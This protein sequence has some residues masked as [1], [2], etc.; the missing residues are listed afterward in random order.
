MAR[1]IALFNEGNFR[2]ALEEFKTGAMLDPVHELSHLYMAACNLAVGEIGAARDAAKRAIEINPKLQGASFLLGFLEVLEEERLKASEHLSKC[3]EL[4]P[5]FVLPLQWAASLLIEERR[6][7]KAKPVVERLLDTKPDSAPANHMS[8]VLALEEGDLSTATSRLERAVELLDDFTAAHRKLAEAYRRQGNKEK[9]AKHYERVIELDKTDADSTFQLGLLLSDLREIDAAIKMF[10]RVLGMKPSL[11]EAHYQI[12]LLLYV[13]KGAIDEAVVELKKALKLDPTDPSTRLILGELLYVKKGMKG[14]WIMVF[15]SW[16]DPRLIAAAFLIPLL[17]LLAFAATIFFGKRLPGK[18]SSLAIGAAAVSSCLSFVLLFYVLSGGRIEVSYPWFQAGK[19]VV[20]IGVTVDP[21]CALMLIVVSIVGLLVE[22][23][24]V[25]YMHGDP[26]FSRYFAYISLFIFSM[27]GLVL[28][29]SFFLLYIFWELVGICS[30]LLIGFWFERK[31]AAD[32]GKKAFITNRVGDFGFLVGVLLLASAAGTF[33]FSQIFSMA[34]HGQFAVGFLTLASVC[35]FA[36]AVGKSAQFPLHVWLPD[37]MEGPTPISALIHAATMVAA[38]V[39]MV[40]RCFPLFSASAQAS[41]VVA[42]IGG[43]TAIFAATIACTQFDIKRVLAYSTLS[44]LGYM[45]LGLG[46]GGYVAGMFH[47]MT[48]AFFKALLFLC[49]GSV[50]HAT[51]KQDI[52]EMGGLG[53]HMKVTSTTFL[54]A[55]LAIAGIPPFSGFWSKDEILVAV[56]RSGHTWLYLIAIAGA[57][58]T[59]FYMFRLYFVV[60]LGEEKCK[61]HES[62]SVMAVPLAILGVLSVCA[63]WVGMPW[64]RHGI[65]SFL[66]GGEGVEHHG[67][68]YAVMGASLLVAGAGI[69]ISYGTYVKG[70]IARDAFSR[71]FAPIYRLLYNKY[72]VDE[73]YQAYIVGPLVLLTKSLFTFDLG[74]I[75]GAVNGTAR[76]TVLWSR[77]K[78]WF[79]VHVVDGAVNGVAFLTRF[80]GSAARRAQTGNLQQYALM[81]IV[82][83]ATILIVKFLL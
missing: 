48:H 62:P 71:R 76:V 70:W 32:A 5:E 59:A 27:Y 49:A 44:Q 13:E 7:S 9:A 74:V 31:S 54:V 68:N 75:D 2:G 60:F 77:V 78:R 14:K 80:A 43:I 45:M 81:I 66:S 29:N 23:Y 72:Y 57:L 67:P 20:A 28:C 47:L 15:T 22:I 6:F 55:C 35:L 52:R 26:R 21:L 41:L 18:G 64:F 37:A 83:L 12:G 61:S 58:L 53:R 30:Y 79:D 36:G 17:P 56:Q 38:G 46:C 25:G 51:E 3:Y 19:Y 24:S 63:G 50:I 39:Y 42:T 82:G 11:A 69:V 65:G 33:Q 16:G 10:K 34:Q 40:A 1:G 73:I 4:N 8:G